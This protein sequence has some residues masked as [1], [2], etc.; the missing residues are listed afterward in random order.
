VR[1]VRGARG[2]GVRRYLR[3]PSIGGGVIASRAVSSPVS[4]PV[5]ARNLTGAGK[6]EELVSLLSAKFVGLLTTAPPAGGV[7]AMT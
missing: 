1:Q 3:W 2:F 7:D 4:P 5:A 6:A